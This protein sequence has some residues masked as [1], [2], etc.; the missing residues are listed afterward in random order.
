MPIGSIPGTI[1]VKWDGYR[2][3]VHVEPGGV[4]AITRGGYDW[5]KKFDLIV[6][7]ARELGHAS[8]ILDGEA[9]VLDD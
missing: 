9:V 4:R 8:I 6:A 3:A 7:E 1:E 5:T 2:L